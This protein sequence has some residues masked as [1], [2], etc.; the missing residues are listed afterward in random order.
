MTLPRLPTVLDA[1]DTRMLA[2]IAI[3]SVLVLWLALVAAVALGVF[4]RLFLLIKGG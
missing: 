2:R 4:V 1:D 3:L